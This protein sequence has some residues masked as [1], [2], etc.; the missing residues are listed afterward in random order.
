MR[1]KRIYDEYQSCIRALL[2]LVSFKTL[3]CLLTKLPEFNPSYANARSI[4]TLSILGVLFSRPSIFP[5]SD[6]GISTKYFAN[7]GFMNSPVDVDDDRWIGARNHSDVKSAQ[8]ALNDSANLLFKQ[9]Q[10]LVLAMIKSDPVAKQE[11]VNFLFKCIQ[12]NLGRGKMQVDRNTVSTD[13]FLY[14]LFQVCLLL[15]DPIM[16]ISFSKLHLIDSNFFM[17]SNQLDVSEDTKLNADK[18]TSD[19]L[20]SEWKT[21]NPS[22]S[23]NFVTEIF[24]ATLS[25]GHFGFLSTARLY[26]NLVKEIQELKGH[27]A[28]IKGMLDAAA[29]PFARQTNEAYLKRFETQLDTMIAQ[30][31]AMEA[32]L[33]DKATLDHVLQF[34]SL[35][36]VWILKL[37]S[38]TN[39]KSI[40]FSQVVRGLDHRVPLIPLPNP[41]MEFITLPEWIIEDICELYLF[42]ARYQAPL[43]ENHPRD[44][45][46]TLAMVLLS[47]SS[48]IKNPYLKSKLVEIMFFFTLPLYRTV[49]GETMGRLDAVFITH[50]WT[51]KHLV[52]AVLKFYVDVEQTG[53][54]SQFYD[55]FNIRYNISQIL[56]CVWN[57]S[58]HAEAIVEQ[59]KNTDFFVK[60]AALLMNDTTYLL[61]EALTKLKEIGS[62]IN[63]LATMPAVSTFNDSKHKKS[64]SNVLKRKSPCLNMNDKLALVWP[65]AK[66]LF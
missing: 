4:E 59:S 12:L 17:Y 15:C 36:I 35:V 39:D 60:F 50:P 28:K 14:N 24:F 33:L 54:H 2:Y 20:W 47:N 58:V 29:N 13:G 64:N 43:F 44:E 32:G 45:I 63:E 49:N 26:G 1:T 25:L 34:Y 46:M 10:S 42:I 30:K 6:P 56:K 27:V 61:D 65:L 62:L 3:S 19:R 31:L 66:K 48:Y 22:N 52:T 40:N 8:S 7:N 37:A 9:L 5:D 23:P 38:G 41:S 16:D 21:N 51:R 18:E 53:M 57:D 11:T 55:K